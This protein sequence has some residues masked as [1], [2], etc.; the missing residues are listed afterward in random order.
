MPV[1]FQTLW[2]NHPRNQSPRQEAPC[3]DASGSRAFEN[4]CAI[5]MSVCLT[6]SG[7]KLPA[8]RGARCWHGHGDRHILRAEQMATWLR[9][10]RIFGDPHV[11]RAGSGVALA[12][13]SYAS[14]TGI[15]FFRNFWGPGNQGDHIDLWRFSRMSGNEFRA[16]YF[17]QSQEIWFWRVL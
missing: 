5:R 12:A 13:S 9:D 16:S 14:R 8:F 10:S 1:P 6:R 7:V 15:I 4:Q 3:R 2:R 17:Q 11:A